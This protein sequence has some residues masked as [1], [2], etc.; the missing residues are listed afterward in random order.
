MLY[1]SSLVVPEYTSLS[2]SSGSLCCMIF[3]YCI[4]SRQSAQAGLVKSKMRA[5]RSKDKAELISRMEVFAVITCLT[6]CEWL[7]V[8][9]LLEQAQVSYISYSSPCCCFTNSSSSC[10]AR[11]QCLAYSLSTPSPSRARRSS[12]CRQQLHSSLLSLPVVCGNLGESEQL[13]ALEQSHEWARRKYKSPCSYCFFAGR[14]MSK[15]SSS[16]FLASRT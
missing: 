16:W 7:L 15:T 8:S 14:S 1:L 2:S 5:T 9:K 12:P 11:S 13:T 10:H 6:I 4:S 3:Q